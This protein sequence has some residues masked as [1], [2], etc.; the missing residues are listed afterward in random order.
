MA[1][2]HGFALI[3]EQDVPEINSHVRLFRHMKTGAELLSVEN[4]D[5]NKSFGITFQTIPQDSTGVPHILEHAVLN[6]S[7][8]YP[9]KEPFVELLKSSMASFINAMTGED[10]TMYP[11]ASQNLQDFYNLIDVYLDAV[12]YPRISPEILMQ[13]GWHYELENPEDDLKFKGV[14]FNEMKGAF[15]SPDNVLFE[16]SRAALFPDNNYQ[17]NSGGDPEVI[18]NLTYEQFR[19]FHETFYHPSNAKIF[20]YGDDSPE[21]RLRL[22]NEYLKDYDK[23][24]IDARIALQAKFDEPIRIVKGYDASAD[25]DN[26]SMMTLSWVLPESAN[27]EQRFAFNMLQHILLGTDAAPL[28]KA[29]TDSGL[30]EDVIGYLDDS[31]KQMVLFTG[32]KGIDEGMTDRI[33]SLILTTLENLVREGIDKASVEASVNTIEFMYREYNTGNFPRGLAMMFGTLSEWMYGGDPIAGLAFEAPLN[34]LK[35]NIAG[36]PRFFEKMIEEHLLNNPHRS[37][38]L[39]QPDTELRAGLEI[40]E[41]ERLIKAREAMTEE[42]IQRVVEETH[43]LQQIQNTPDTP[44]ALA[45][46]PSLTPADLEKLINTVPLEI[47]DEQGTQVLY[48]D[49][50]TNSI[51][52]LD[53][54]FDLHALP[55]EYLPYVSL[56]SAGLLEMGTEKEDFVRLSQRIGSKTGGISPSRFLSNMRTG[57][58]DTAWLLMSGKATVDHTDDLLD[59]LRDILLTTNF[60]NQERFLQ[61]A[62]KAKARKESSLVPAGHQVI[63]NRMGAY[64]DTVGWVSEQ[65]GGI[66]YLFFLRQLIDQIQ[67]DWP[68][69]LQ[70]LES[71]RDYL[72][73]RD[74]MLV[75]IT[76]DHEN[77]QQVQPKLAAFIA[78]MPQKSMNAPVWTPQLRTGNEGLTIPAQVNYVGKAGNLFDY[79]YERHSSDSVISKFLSRTWLWDKIRVQGGAYGAFASFDPTS[80][81]FKYA[82]YRDP[83]LLGSLEAYDKTQEFLRELTLNEEEI[84][85]LIV[86]VIGDMDAYQLPDA[87]GRSSMQR[88]LIGYSDEMRQ[89]TRNEILETNLNHFRAFSDVLAAL[90]EKGVVVVMGSSEAI[91]K[92]NVEHANLLP[93]T[94]VL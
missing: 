81:V 77:W 29:L 16:S 72:L 64:F 34:A 46:I 71:V 7:R 73:R 50:F 42:D 38:L 8:K 1:E 25:S 49:L 4:D 24:D 9:V 26:K 41:R 54:A 28:R 19:R 91:E 65:M 11:V 27:T 43:K 48:H 35:N 78:D 2:I 87:K 70:T 86:G 89:Q 31:I 67:N 88:Y 18:P 83:N 92:V 51:V 68:G 63:M 22:L 30:G 13:E 58:G 40:A 80:G 52:Y 21:E 10:R 39:L 60:D 37:T 3:R 82:S 33:E 90:K 5:E 69:V 47:L 12:F 74:V 44:E 59:I 84:G 66:E 79:G 14:V 56:F 75:N 62:L 23:L 32:M 6:G 94:K 45:T 76:L 15:S 85:R 61:L 36:D 55:Q 93:V 20:F 57:E 17:Y 53:V